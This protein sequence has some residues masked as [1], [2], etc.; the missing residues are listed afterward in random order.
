M[1]A[2]ARRLVPTQQGLIEEMH[3]MQVPVP[4]ILAELSKTTDVLFTNKDIYNHLQRSQKMEVDALSDVQKLLQ[5]ARKNPNI[6]YQVGKGF[7]NR[8]SWFTFGS[9]KALE[10][11][12]SLNFVL[13][14]WTQRTERIDSTC[15]Y[16]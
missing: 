1:S 9:R 14:I 8:L 16:F 3:A 10:E 4:L 7:E 12:T 13:L 11:F 5:A 15:R 6:I 2:V